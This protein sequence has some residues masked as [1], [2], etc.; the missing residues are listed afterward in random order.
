MSAIDTMDSP[1]QYTKQLHEYYIKAANYTRLFREYEPYPSASTV[2]MMLDDGFRA[3]TFDIYATDD[4][5]LRVT[6]HKFNWDADLT[7]TEVLTSIADWVQQTKVFLPIILTLHAS[8][9]TQPSKQFANNIAPAIVQKVL[10]V[11]PN[12]LIV[13]R[14]AIDLYKDHSSGV[15]NWQQVNDLAGKLFIVIDA[16]DLAAVPS[17]H[18]KYIFTSDMGP[19]AMYEYQNI[20]KFGFLAK[21]FGDPHIKNRTALRTDILKNRLIYVRPQQKTGFFNKKPLDFAYVTGL[22]CNIVPVATLK[23]SVKFFDDAIYM[24]K[25]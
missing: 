24:E 9:T 1:F 20:R 14:D 4:E 23:T 6:H 19:I 22:S 16:P 2:F 15:Y 17:D 25:L 21:I 3:F 5:G 13:T 7:L 12:Q 11:L 10:E 18:V 8:F